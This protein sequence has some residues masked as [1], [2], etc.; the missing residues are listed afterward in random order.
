[1]IGIVTVK[2]LCSSNELCLRDVLNTANMTSSTHPCTQGL[3]PEKGEQDKSRRCLQ[4]CP[5]KAFRKLRH[6]H[7]GWGT[8]SYPG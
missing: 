3:F 6:Q 1:M 4:R 8:Q 7:A 2:H 5:L